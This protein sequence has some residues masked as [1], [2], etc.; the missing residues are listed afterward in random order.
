MEDSATY[1]LQ[2]DGIQRVMLFGGHHICS[3]DPTGAIHEL[4]CAD[5]KSP[6]GDIVRPYWSSHSA[7]LRVPRSGCRAAG[8]YD[9]QKAVRYI[10]IAGGVGINPVIPLPECDLFDTVTLTIDPIASMQHPRTDHAMVEYNGSVV[11]ICGWP[12]FTSCEQLDMTQCTWMPFPST[13][14]SRAH[15][16][17]AV[18]DN[19]IFLVGHVSELEVF[20][21]YVWIIYHTSGIF[22]RLLVSSI[23]LGDRLILLGGTRDEIHAFN[24]KTRDTTTI[25]PTHV[26]FSRHGPIRS[27]YSAI[28]F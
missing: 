27:P 4:M 23:V 21:G 5:G 3:G 25:R 7:K 11:V 14:C 2:Q 6:S 15:C 18:A 17:A 9:S 13:N 8:I 1:A 26:A 12:G 22:S 20:D 19:N 28:A 24:I 16:G 10:I